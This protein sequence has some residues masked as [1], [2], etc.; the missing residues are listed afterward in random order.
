MTGKTATIAHQT[1]AELAGRTSIL[2][3]QRSDHTRLD[4]LMTRARQTVEE[5]G[6]AHQVALRAVAR[7]VFTTPS[8]RSQCCSPRHGG[9]FRRGT[10]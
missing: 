3:R 8:P 5:G 6:I 1:L 2:A 10:R 9:S 7:L 4:Q